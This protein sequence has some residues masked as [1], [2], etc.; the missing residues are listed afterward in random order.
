MENAENKQFT[1]KVG[2]FVLKYRWLIILVN[3]LV[4]GGYLRLSVMIFIRLRFMFYIGKKVRSEKMKS[5]ISEVIS[6][7]TVTGSR[8]IFSI[9]PIASRQTGNR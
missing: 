6:L 2:N 4:L 5:S 9:F 1:T 7:L 3:I 8:L